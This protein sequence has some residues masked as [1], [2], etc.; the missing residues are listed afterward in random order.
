MLIA[1]RY[2]Q[3][4][5]ENLYIYENFYTMMVANTLILFT[6]T[7][8]G[9][10]GCNDYKLGLFCSYWVLGSPPGPAIYYRLRHQ[11]THTTFT[12]LISHTEVKI[13]LRWL[14]GAFVIIIL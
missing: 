5:T 1:Y 7:Y 6:V 10:L 11:T 8:H 3:N 2:L 13:Y 4:Y 14:G 12:A 9:Y